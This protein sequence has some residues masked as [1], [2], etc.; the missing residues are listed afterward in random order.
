MRTFTARALMGTASLCAI[1][2]AQPA[3]AS[4]K[5]P[6]SLTLA[7]GAQ[8]DSNVAVDEAEINARKGDVAALAQVSAGYKL[9][10]SKT[11]LLHAGYD[12]DQTSYA[13]LGD[14]DLQVHRLSLGASLESGKTSFGGDYAFSHVLLG[15]DGY[16]DMH[17]LSPS[18]TTF[19][20]DKLLL[21]ASYIYLDKAF[22]DS[23]RLDAHTHIGSVDA[24]RYFAGRKAYVAVGL[25][26]DNEDAHAP[27]LDYQGF[28]AS[29]RAQFP[30]SLAGIKAK[31]RL[32]YSYAERDYRHVTP[33]IGEKRDESRHTVSASLD[34]PLG[35]GFSFKP[36]L[37]Y[38]DR[39]SNLPSADYDE[40]VVSSTLS[41]KL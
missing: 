13:D 2:M 12:F 33:S 14:Y 26:Y 17:M 37:R 9:I 19:A 38:M 8:Y 10:D 22:L 35:G 32:G 1:T 16:L 24:Y 15:G 18:I 3:S 31:A 20:G 40:Y 41:Y 4:D 25:R 5:P 30:V 39:N 23:D 28:Q 21:R 27:E 11:L 7:L 36:Q 6:V 29:A 34:T